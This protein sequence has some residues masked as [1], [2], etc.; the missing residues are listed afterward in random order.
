MKTPHDTKELLH[1]LHQTALFDS[2]SP[3]ELMPFVQ[4]SF[5]KD[6]TAK[7]MI[8]YEGDEANYFFIVLSGMVRLYRLTEEGK[9]K[10][11]EFIRPHDSFAEAVVFLKG[12]YPVCAEAVEH[13]ELLAVSADTILQELTQSPTLALK[14]LANLSRRLH[15]FIKDIHTLSL[16]NAQQRVAGFLL[17]MADEKTCH[18]PFSKAMIASRLGL[19]PESFS[20]VLT[21]LKSEQIVLEKA[22]SLEI[23]DLERLRC[24]QKGIK[25]SP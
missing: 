1:A 22:Q 14:L 21:R 5:K 18:L 4:T 15:V 16:E 9:E 13:S 11:I 6:Y 25:N 2:L 19:S 3:D 20:R 24:L 12:T 10:V 17:A 23:I 7:Q 8:F